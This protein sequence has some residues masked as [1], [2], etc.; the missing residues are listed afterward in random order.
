MHDVHYGCYGLDQ[1]LDLVERAMQA[2][3]TKPR[4]LRRLADW[5]GHRADHDR[6]RAAGRTYRRRRDHAA[7]GW[8]LRTDR[9]H[10][11]IRQRHLDRASP[12]RRQRARHHGRSDPVSLQSDTAHGGHDTGAYGSTGTFVAGRRRSSRP[13]TSPMIS[14]FLPPLRPGA[15]PTLASSKTMPRSAAGSACPLPRSRSRARARTDAAAPAA[16]LPA[17]RARSHSMCRAFASP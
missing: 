14:G 10:R 15:T 5:R 2:R 11:R 3:R 7:R 12:D 9:R 6:Y 4:P 1:C 13:R 17:R 16:H 8:R